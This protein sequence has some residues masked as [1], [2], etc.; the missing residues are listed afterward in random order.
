MEFNLDPRLG[1]ELPDLSTPFESLSP[2]EQ[3]D[4]VY[5]WEGIRARIPERIMK[6][7]QVIEDIL[8]AIHHEEDWDTIASYFAEISDYA[9][10]IA[11]LNTWRRVDQSLHGAPTQGNFNRGQTSNAPLDH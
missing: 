2:E 6:F 11:E 1:I 8:E 4:V 10:R 9:S 3:E 7:E 5:Q